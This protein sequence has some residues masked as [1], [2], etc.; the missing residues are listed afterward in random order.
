MGLYRAQ[1]I[2]SFIYS[3][4]IIWH[5]QIDL[6]LPYFRNFLGKILFSKTEIKHFWQYIFFFLSLSTKKKWKNSMWCKNRPQRESGNTRSVKLRCIFVEVIWTCYF[7][8]SLL[9][10]VRSNFLCLQDKQDRGL[11]KCVVVYL[12][13]T[14]ST[15]MVVELKYNQIRKRVPGVKSGNIP[16]PRS[17]PGRLWAPQNLPRGRSWAIPSG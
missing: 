11:N 12:R 10:E 14:S 2:V 6:A 15:K 17:Y 1:N 9:A 16:P 7:V 8:S 3:R 5:Q 4:I 13:G